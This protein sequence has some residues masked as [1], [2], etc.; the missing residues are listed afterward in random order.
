MDTVARSLLVDPAGDLDDIEAVALTNPTESNLALAFV[1]HF[2]SKLLYCAELG[3][4]LFW[5]GTHWRPERT[6][7]AFHY[8]VELAR[9][10]AMLRDGGKAIAKASFAAGVE[11][12]A[13]AERVFAI[14]A[15]ELDR[16]P[17]LIA[18]PE[19][20]YDLRGDVM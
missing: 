1:A 19:G 10:A 8:C 18:T 3:T 15:D 20:S 7:L 16:D 11:R 13:R 12:I 9:R 17:L 14:R 2:R 6:E 5:T 4:W